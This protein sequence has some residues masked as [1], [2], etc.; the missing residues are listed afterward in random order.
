MIMT[1]ERRDPFEVID[2]YNQKILANQSIAAIRRVKRNGTV[3]ESDI[4]TF[5]KLSKL[6]DAAY[7]GDQ[8]V[9]GSKIKA[10]SKYSL[11][12]LSQTLNAMKGQLRD[13][14]AFREHLEFLQKS[15]SKLA[16]GTPIPD[17]ELNL[18]FNF[19]KRYSDLQKQLLKQPS[20]K[21]S[22]GVTV[23][24]FENQTGHT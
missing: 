12:I 11:K 21:P 20:V 4:D 16:K 13:T 2:I 24:P 10:S 19:C 5:K 1:G 22:Y 8:N 18:L 6:L 15:A 9:S 17:E 23:W 3:D 14:K 7:I